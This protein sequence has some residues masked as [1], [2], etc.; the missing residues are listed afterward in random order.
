MPELSLIIMNDNISIL[1]VDVGA[2]PPL[3]LIP[4][5][6]DDPFTEQASPYVIEEV[7][8]KIRV[9]VI[10][11]PFVVGTFVKAQFVTDAPNIPVNTEG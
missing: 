10:T 9:I 11:F 4:P 8:C 5:D 3:H 7:P 1:F 2:D 6:I